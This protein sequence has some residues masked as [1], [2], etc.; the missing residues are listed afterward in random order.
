M[1]HLKIFTKQRHSNKPTKLLDF[2]NVSELIT[3]IPRPHLPAKSRHWLKAWDDWRRRS[4]SSAV[5]RGGRH[6]QKLLARGAGGPHG[7]DWKQTIAETAWANH[8]GDGQGCLA[9]VNDEQPSKEID[10][11]LNDSVWDCSWH[12]KPTMINWILSNVSMG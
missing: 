6:R 5:L 9:A 8:S 10:K 2:P 1:E 7:G 3:S 12:I 11:E 4:R